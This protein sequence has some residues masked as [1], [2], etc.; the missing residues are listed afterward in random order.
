MLSLSPHS[1]GNIVIN[2]LI[3][4]ITICAASGSLKKLYSEPFDEF[5]FPAFFNFFFKFLMKIKCKMKL[6]KPLQFPPII[7]TSLM[8]SFISGNVFKANARLVNGPTQMSVISFG[9][10]EIGSC[11]L[12]D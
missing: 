9:F 3:K 6:N 12:M 11:F 1:S 4:L 8:Y 2:V 5:P 7:K 10:Y